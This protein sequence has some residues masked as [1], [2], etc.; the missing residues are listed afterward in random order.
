M[1]NLNQIT[2]VGR[3]SNHA[4]IINFAGERIGFEFFVMV[5][6]PV[7]KINH[8]TA[9]TG[10]QCLPV[11]VMTFPG[12]STAGFDF[13]PGKPIRII[14]QYVAGSVEATYAEYSN[15]KED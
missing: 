13:A 12:C 11:K 14:G 6:G 7:S 10:Y 3:T 1:E 5:E 8:N 4:K 9:E 2:L 15:G